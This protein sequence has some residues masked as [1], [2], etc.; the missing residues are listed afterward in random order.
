[1]RVSST[2]FA[3]GCGVMFMASAAKGGTITFSGVITQSTFDGTGPAVNNP[4]LNNIQDLQAYTVTLV[5]P[6]T[7]TMPGTYNLT[8]SNL[9]FDVP[10][11][12]ASETGFDSISLTITANADFDDLSLL[13]CLTAGSGCSFGNQ[14]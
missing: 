3:I 13:G 12:P 10:S 5:F 6:G 11:A 4:S 9:T 14:L 7:I 1:M 8:G 2:F